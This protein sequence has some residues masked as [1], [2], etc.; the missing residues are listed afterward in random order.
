MPKLRREARCFDSILQE[1]LAY[2][3]F[4]T[5][6]MQLDIRDPDV[7]LALDQLD[8]VSKALFDQ[9]QSD[10]DRTNLLHARWNF[11]VHSS[12][13]LPLVLQLHQALSSAADF[14]CEYHLRELQEYLEGGALLSDY[15]RRVRDR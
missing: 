11:P 6:D 8:Q 12:T 2:P 4:E 10:T 14:Q 5:N 7:L 15:C 1:A 13:G 9:I 3:D